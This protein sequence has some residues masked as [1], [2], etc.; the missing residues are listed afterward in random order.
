MYS[1]AVKEPHVN[2]SVLQLTYTRV[3][4]IVNS[5]RKWLVLFILLRAYL[6]D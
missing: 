3:N 6:I 5:T 1:K 2:R 4:L